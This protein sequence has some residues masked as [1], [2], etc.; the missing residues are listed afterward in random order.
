VPRCRRWCPVRDRGPFRKKGRVAAHECHWNNAGWERY[1]RDVTENP[2]QCLRCGSSNPVGMKFCGMCG[3]PLAAAPL[4]EPAD[5]ILGSARDGANRIVEVEVPAQSASQS[6]P[7]PAYTGGAFRLMGQE[8]HPSSSRSLDYLLDDDEEPG[9]GRGLWMVGLLLALA[10]AGGLGYWHYRNGGWPGIKT[11]GGSGQDQS[12]ATGAA[13]D[14]TVSAPAEAGGSGQSPD[15]QP[16]AAA[17]MTDVHPKNPSAPLAAT[18]E[19]PTAAD[20]S[21]TAPAAGTTKPAAAEHAAPAASKPPAAARA[22]TPVKAEDPVTVGEKYIYGRGAPQNCER[23]LKLVRPAADVF[24]GKAMITM[25]A[26]YATGHCVTRDLPTAYRYFALALRKDPEN[27]ALKQNAEM[28]WG[29]MTQSERQQ[30][31]RLTQ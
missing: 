1:R 24:N 6:G 29:Q 19:A 14:N 26:L 25:G 22:E 15:A 31:I 18:P 20:T 8:V 5:P 10:L 2:R 13:A 30:A 17:A 11:A 16:P 21:P 27:A 12:A 28:V 7:A 3:A 23:G 9:S 4:E